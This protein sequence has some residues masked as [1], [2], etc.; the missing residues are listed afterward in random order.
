[1]YS[2]RKFAHHLLDAETRMSVGGMDITGNG[3]KSLTTGSEESLF[4]NSEWLLAAHTASVHKRIYNNEANAAL[5]KHIATLG[6]D[7]DNPGVGYVLEE[8]ETPKPGYMRVGSFV[9][10][11][12]QAVALMNEIAVPWT[13]D[14]PVLRH[15]AANALR[16][17]S[18]GAFKRLAVTGINPAFALSNLPRDIAHVLVLTDTYSNALPIGLAQLT[19]DIKK[20][21]ADVWQRKGRYTEYINEGGGMDFL[22]YQGKPLTG[23]DVSLEQSIGDRVMHVA[24]YLN[25]TSELLVRIAIRER[26]ITKR[27]AAFAKAHGRAPSKEEL[28]DIKREATAKAREQ[29]D[30]GQGGQTAKF[31]DNL[32]PY[33]NATLQGT[34]VMVR[35][36]R[37]D[38]KRFAAKLAQLGAFSVALVLYNMRFDEW[39]E[40]PDH[41]KENNF[42]IFLPFT[43]TDENGH[44]RRMYLKIPKSQD[45]RAFAGAFEGMAEFAKTGKFPTKRSTHAF[46]EALPIKPTT[47]LDIPLVDAMNTYLSNYDRFHDTE[48]SRGYKKVEP[49]KEYTP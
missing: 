2:P 38:P 4:N 27:T 36:A 16:I 21:S 17:V 14:N 39:D 20:V 11:K 42:I 28:A 5:H 1:E 33:F 7:R 31:I 18:G 45:Q 22:T 29:M 19:A 6:T 30:F 25:E 13:A 32:I 37:T 15:D 41:E 3:I 23:G 43:R 26:E 40:V 49:W 46:Y 47:P 10:G 8:G 34:R 24:G 44:V 9:D 12:E 48:V 35:T